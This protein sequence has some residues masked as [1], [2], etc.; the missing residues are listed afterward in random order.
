MDTTYSRVEF[1]TTVYSCSTDWLTGQ[2]PKNSPQTCSSHTTSWKKNTI[3]S[4]IHRLYHCFLEVKSPFGLNTIPCHHASPSTTRG[5]NSFIISYPHCSLNPHHFWSFRFSAPPFSDGSQPSRGS[6]VRLN[7]ALAG[8]LSLPFCSDK[9]PAQPGCGTW[10]SP[11]LCSH[12]A[13]RPIN[14]LKYI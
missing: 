7:W 8:L 11:L 6:S 14:P 9:A 3:R 2:Y 1:L 5:Q 10:L 4:I 13:N 12:L